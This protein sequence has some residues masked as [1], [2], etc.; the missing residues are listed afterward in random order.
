MAVDRTIPTTGPGT[1]AAQAALINEEIGRLYN[2]IPMIVG[3]V[4]GTANAITGT[5]TPSVTALTAGQIYIL[6]PASQTTSTVTFAVNGL[7]A[8]AVVDKTGSAL[9]VS[10]FMRAG[11]TY[12]L[13]YNGTNFRILND[14]L[15]NLV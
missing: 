4:A 11:T 12:M 7:T 2:S 5:V 3:S 8:L 15:T 10:K 13:L 1:Y 14:A 6:T 9:S